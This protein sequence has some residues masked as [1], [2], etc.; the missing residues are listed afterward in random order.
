MYC[1]FTFSGTSEGR[2][3]PVPSH[4]GEVLLSGCMWPDQ[5]ECEAALSAG[6]CVSPSTSFVTTWT[7]L[8]ALCHSLLVRHGTAGSLPL[9][10]PPTRPHLLPHPSQVRNLWGMLWS[11][12]QADQLPHW[13]SQ[14]HWEGGQ[15]HRE[16]PPPLLPWA[17]PGGDKR[18]PACRQLRGAEQE[19][20]HAPLSDME[21]DGWTP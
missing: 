13:W 14:R 9:W 21:G 15:H 16:S 5:T 7:L 8:P 20:Y 18:T 12:P 2:G 10:P 6:R 4:E 19:Q 17:W 1:S 11:H 3:T